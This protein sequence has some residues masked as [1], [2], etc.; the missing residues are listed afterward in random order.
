MTMT[1]IWIALLIAMEPEH[2][3]A[4]VGTHTIHYRDIACNREFIASMLAPGLDPEEACRAHE[5]QE[6]H[7]TVRKQLL[8]IAANEHN[9]A[10]PAEEAV[11][12]KWR[13]PSL[14]R[15]MTESDRLVA[16][17][18]LRVIRGEQADRVFD[19]EL[20]PEV[21]RGK[22]FDQVTVPRAMFESLLKIF[23]TEGDVHK[24]LASISDARNRRKIE[25]LF[26]EEATARALRQ[27]VHGLSRE[28][29]IDPDD[30]QERFWCDLITRTNSRVL[31]S[32]FQFPDLKRLV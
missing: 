17:A 28:S 32:R 25:E 26:V 2:A 6:F 21:L 3:I 20:A 29:A 31:D 9:I 11:P 14:V 22:G 19:E 13:D 30:A 1:G 7:R 27:I 16:S 5:E 24:R 23:K 8:A 10:I 4:I 18:A 12:K 15:Q